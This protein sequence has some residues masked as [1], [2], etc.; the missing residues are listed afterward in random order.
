[1]SNSPNS[2]RFLRSSN[3]CPRLESQLPRVITATQPQEPV[4]SVKLNNI[5]VSSSC[6]FKIIQ[7]S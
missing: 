6:S 2:Y 3:G 1:M 5:G 7:E 4:I